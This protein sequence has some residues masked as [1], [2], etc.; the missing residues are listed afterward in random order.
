[1]KWHKIGKIFDPTQHLL[2]NGC[3]QFAQSPQALVLNDYVRIYF[4]TRVMDENG[5]YLSH[6]AFVDMQ[7]NLRDIICVSN[8]TVIPLGKRGCFDEHG[9]FPMNVLQ[10][11]DEVLG[12]TCGWNRRT[13]VSVE[14]AIGLAI[15]CD[16]GLTFRRIGDGPVLSA[17]LN[18]PYLVGDGFVKII[19]D[20]FHMWYIFGTCWKQYAPD[21]PPDRTYKIGHATSSNGI[22][23]IK[24]DA[25]QIIPD[26]IGS[27]E[28]QALPTVIDL[29]GRYNM[30]F[31]Y[32]PSFNYRKSK[33]RGYR[34]GHAWSDDLLN[35][36]RD[37]NEARLEGTPGE[38]DSDMQC[39]PHVFECDGKVFLLY[40]GNEFGRYGFGIAELQ[41]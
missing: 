29:A 35:W 41:I 24:E 22:E 13:S 30:F 28:C 36:T 3:A 17:T 19:G 18:E 20:T 12:Y 23:W 1:M 27:D 31:C 15:S 7:K 34:I 37:D 39:Y 21:I 26:K 2:P 8:Q 40:N 11:G 25:R 5:K 4:S 9:I 16:G 38:W 14:T 33:G 6:I 32:R 10:H